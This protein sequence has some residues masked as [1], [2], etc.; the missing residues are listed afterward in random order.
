MTTIGK[1]TPRSKD[2]FWAELSGFISTLA[3]QA[4]IR[5]SR[6][7]TVDTDSTSPTHRVS[8]RG[9][10]GDYVEIGAGWSKAMKRGANS[11]DEFLSVTLDDPSFPH[12]LNFAVFRDE[13]NALATWRRRQVEAA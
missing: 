6:R 9:P 10:Q 2:D 13:D 3:F 7:K 4:D 5:I 12:P 1:L 11:G 8:V